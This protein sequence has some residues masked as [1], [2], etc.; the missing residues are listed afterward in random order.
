MGD[1]RRQT[2]RAVKYWRER[3]T[4]FGYPPIKPT[5]LE[6][7]NL[8]ADNGANQFI[9]SID[10]AADNHVLLTYGT[11][12]ARLLDLPAGMGSRIRLIH[13]IP[14]RLLPM[15]IQGCRDVA[16]N[17]PPLRLQGAID[18]DGDRQQLYRAVFMPIGVNLVFG[19][20]NACLTDSK[21][22]RR[23]LERVE[24]RD[25]RSMEAAIAAFIRL[26]G[27]TRCP[28]A[29][30]VPTRASISQADRAALERYAVDRERLRKQKSAI[31]HLSFWMIVAP[32]AE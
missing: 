21:A 1:E 14:A 25:A 7:D 22:P 9:I 16:L 29:Y 2:E 32:P 26:K 13:E 12:F 17:E 24:K 23:R 28:T 4:K 11:D 3:V 8:I 30:A 10:P 15:F 18:M 27:V 5:D 6:F 19:A 31:Q 20:F